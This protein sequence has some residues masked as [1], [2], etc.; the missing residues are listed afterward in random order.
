LLGGGVPH[1][2]KQAASGHRGFF[3]GRRIG[4]CVGAP[5]LSQM[6]KI[7]TQGSDYILARFHADLN[8]DMQLYAQSDISRAPIG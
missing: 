7:P 5:V 8:I 4:K 3:L 1:S 2:Y 6:D